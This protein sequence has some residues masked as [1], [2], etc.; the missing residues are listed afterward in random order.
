MARAVYTHGVSLA[1]CTPALQVYASWIAGTT[2][3]TNWVV[4]ALSASLGV[5]ANC[6]LLV[7]NGTAAEELAVVCSPANVFALLG[8]TTAAV[9]L[10]IAVFLG[11]IKRGHV[12]SF[13]RPRSCQQNAALKFSST[14]RGIQE[15]MITA[16]DPVYWPREAVR[17]FIA[18]H[19]A[20]WE[21]DP[22]AWFADPRWRAALPGECRPDKEAQ[23]AARLE[24][25]A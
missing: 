23:Q 18:S 7:A 2:F 19:W 5:A 4:L 11:S 3:A 8:A 24:Q 10:S 9:V 17:V 20:E 16:R 1:F 6:D 22:P 25:T 13:F 21:A 14:E 15:L 12:G